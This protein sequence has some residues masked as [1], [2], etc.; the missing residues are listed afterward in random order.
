[1]SNLNNAI[2]KATT[3]MLQKFNNRLNKSQRESEQVMHDWATY[4]AIEKNF[5]VAQVGCAL[6]SLMS[7]GPKFMPSAYEI[8]AE[9]LPTQEK[10]ED[11][12]PVIANEIITLIRSYHS[13]LEDNMLEKAS[14]DA[15][16]VFLAIGNTSDI[17]TSENFE[18]TKAQLERMIKGVLASKESRFKK[19]KLESIGLGK[20]LEMRTMDYSN[21]LPNDPT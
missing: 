12:A 1:M 17:R 21:Y 15:R 8:E 5:T 11:L 13:D 4:L 16:L 6:S 19:Q 14:P 9:L 2:L 7:K 20:V 18:T 10:K 3:S